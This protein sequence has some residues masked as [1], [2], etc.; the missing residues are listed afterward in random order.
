MKDKNY[1]N[2]INY[3]L[4]ECITIDSSAEPKLQLKLQTSRQVISSLCSRAEG[5]RKVINEIN[6]LLQQICSKS[7]LETNLE[8]AQALSNLLF[9]LLTSGGRYQPTDRTLVSTDVA[10]LL[11]EV[12]MIK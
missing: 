10:K 2:I 12:D 3:I 8:L 5:R 9:A 6:T 7:K 4:R 1:T 11:L